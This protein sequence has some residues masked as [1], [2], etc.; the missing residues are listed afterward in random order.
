MG[1]SILRLCGFNV[2]HPR[3]VFSAANWGRGSTPDVK[4][5]LSDMAE[6]T[7]EMTGCIQ[8]EI[9]E[10]LVHLSDLLLPSEPDE[11]LCEMLGTDIPVRGVLQDFITS[12]SSMPSRKEKRSCK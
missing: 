10:K 5:W 1:C 3:A 12:F 8:R 4:A 7:A 6:M 2:T 11:Q 9:G